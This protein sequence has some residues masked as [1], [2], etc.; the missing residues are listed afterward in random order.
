MWGGAC[1]CVCSV[2]FHMLITLLP[3]CKFSSYVT[4][5]KYLSAHC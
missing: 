4:Y 2:V 3:V 1:T 5:A